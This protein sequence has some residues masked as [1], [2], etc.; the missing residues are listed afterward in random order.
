MLKALIFDFDGVIVDTETQ[1]YEIYRDW[2]KEEYN[3]DLNI[4]DYLVCV[5]ANSRELFAFLR[6]AIGPE[7]I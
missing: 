6:E 3:Y 2:L 7:V 4:R 1:W 5:G